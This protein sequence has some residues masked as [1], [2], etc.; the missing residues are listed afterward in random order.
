M[1]R[2]LSRSESLTGFAVLLLLSGIAVGIFLK[3]FH[4][5]ASLYTAPAVEGDLGA[6]A[7]SGP[8]VTEP[9]ALSLSIPEGVTPLT[10]VETFGPGTLSDKI[11][12]KAELYLSAGF[13]NLQSRRFA[14]E[15]SPGVWFETF[16][17]DMGSPRNAFAVFSSQ[18][19]ADGTDLDGVSLA[20]ATPNAVFLVQD[21]FYVEMVASAPK[22]TLA[23][24]MEAWARDLIRKGS[25]DSGG[26]T[27]EKAFP[28]ENLQ[29]GS[30]TLLS[31][32]VF[33]FEGLNNVF[34]AQYSM[35]GRS[36]SAF[37]SLRKTPEEAERLAADYHDFLLRSGGS[38]DEVPCDVPDCRV[39]QVFDTVEVFFSHGGF[40]AGVHEAENA[41]LGTEMALRLYKR[42]ME[43]AP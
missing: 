23:R 16:V 29:A 8:S 6:T 3:Q 42:L 34:I 18:R 31:S 36:L 14:L 22:E 21:Q 38:D 35:E 4:Y 11:N 20:Y 10:P 13:L 41:A 1:K 40:L 27:E 28:T 15:G 37:L 12:G 43:V 7:S 5:D 30:L 39:V 2:T 25:S 17:Y 19:R 32:D 33:G 26:L 9:A 24:V